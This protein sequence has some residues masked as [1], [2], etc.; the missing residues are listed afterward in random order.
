MSGINS[1][2]SW[3]IAIFLYVFTFSLA[4]AASCPVAS[5]P[6]NVPALTKLPP[7]ALQ[8]DIAHP[9][10]VGGVVWIKGSF[11]AI[12]PDNKVRVLQ[13]DSAVHLHDLL[14]TDKNSE[15]EIVYTDNTLM[16]FQESTKFY[17]KNYNYH[18]QSQSTVK[19][20]GEYVGQV[21]VG[22]FRTVTGI[23]AKE[24]PGNYHMTM[25]TV[26]IG[27]RGTDYAAYA[28]GTKAYATR[29]AGRPVLINSSGTIELSKD[30]PF[31][32]VPDINVAPTFIAQK[33]EVFTKQLV[34]V[35]AMIKATQPAISGKINKED[36]Q[37]IDTTNPD[38]PSGSGGVCNV[39]GG[40]VIKMK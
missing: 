20:V 15:A 1:K 21:I 6:V 25:P 10:T 27:V 5:A 17:V 3:I 13:K 29:Y 7:S 4:N 35:P 8:A 24:N 39:Q 18:P 36:T 23:I 31:G 30:H 32:Y 11:K 40:F 34:I 38:Q 22:G 33:P 19:A 9:T 26:T 37:V 16:T 12:S 2:F 28:C 14:V